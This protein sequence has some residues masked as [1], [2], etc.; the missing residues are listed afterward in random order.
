[1]VNFVFP[2]SML[3]NTNVRGTMEIIRM[4][5]LYH[6]KKIHFISSISVITES[7]VNAKI[8][9]ETDNFSKLNKPQKSYAK[10]KYVAEGICRSAIEKGFPIVI[11]RPGYVAGHSYTG[12][13]NEQD[14][15]YRL[16]VGMIQLNKFPKQLNDYTLIELTPVDY[17]SKSVVAI[18]LE[19]S[20]P[21]ET[22]HLTSKPIRFS[23]LISFIK[24]FGYELEEVEH[25]YFISEILLDEDNPL[26]V[27]ISEVEENIPSTR[28]YEN[29]RA[30]KKLSGTDISCPELDEDLVHTYLK[31]FMEKKKIPPPLV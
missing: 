31:N 3:Y 20:S 18:S 6:L 13:F 22:F 16:V 21:G 17:V 26:Y 9:N 1:L 30:T 27:L 15:I 8:I 4:S 2:Y 29:Y 12:H 28:E 11:Y 19:E 24:S 7:F 14:L 5:S 23:K 10:S 25:Y